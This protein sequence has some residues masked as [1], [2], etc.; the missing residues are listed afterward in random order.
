M[1]T[2]L[3]L[4]LS[5][6]TANATLIDLTPGGYGPQP[7]I[8]TVVVDFFQNHLGPVGV[9]EAG[10]TALLLLLGIAAVVIPLGAMK[11]RQARRTGPL[12]FGFLD[13]LDRIYAP[14]FPVRRSNRNTR[15]SNRKR[16]ASASAIK[17]RA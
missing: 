10:S 14:A 17:K 1:R 16:F 3:I 8:P 5:P 2:L 11:R 12:T 13:S 15:I 4:L 9:P 6:G 7:P